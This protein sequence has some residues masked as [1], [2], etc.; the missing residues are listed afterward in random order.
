MLT[1]VKSII[2][3]S[4]SLEG[5]TARE[6]VLKI[7]E[8]WHYHTMKDNNNKIVWEGQYD[9]YPF[10]KYF[11]I[12]DDLSGQSVIDIGTATGF[13]AFECEKRGA[14]PVVATEL[15]NITDWDTK[16]GYD[17]NGV[18]MPKQN[19][20]DYQEMARLLNSKVKLHWGSINERLHETLGTFDLVIFGALITHLRDPMLALENV[21]LLT[22]GCAVI[23]ASYE[24]GEKHKVL[25]WANS[26][27]PFDWWIPSKSV[28]P[29][30]LYAAGFKRVEEISDF[31]LQHRNGHKQYMA[32]WHAYV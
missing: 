27:R 21:R 25:H 10:W 28:I 11:G 24:P 8:R 2:K 16:A 15:N 12:P 23:I 13:Y 20:L 17:Y 5:D 22:K 18:N 31:V 1:K 4:L 6:E 29:D 7:G 30:M 32:C 26:T 14:M 3:K 19:Q 9:L